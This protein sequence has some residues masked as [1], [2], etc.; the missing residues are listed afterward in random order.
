MAPLYFTDL[1]VRV[2]RIA[3]RIVEIEVDEDKLDTLAGVS[4]RSQDDVA[5]DVCRVHRWIARRHDGAVTT[6][7]RA[8]HVQVTFAMCWTKHAATTSI[9]YRLQHSLQ[10]IMRV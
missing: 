5:L 4:S 8:D 2:A 6:C 7:R 10:W 1:L 3:Y 9:M